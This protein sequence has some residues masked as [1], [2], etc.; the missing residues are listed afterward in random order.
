MIGS[1]GR[2]GSRDAEKKFF[3]LFLRI[4]I[5][6]RGKVTTTSVGA[7]DGAPG[8]LR[9]VVRGEYNMLRSGAEPVDHAA[10]LDDVGEQREPSA[11]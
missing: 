5:P 3:L 6:K 1:R 7:R 4:R 8:G 2:A 11:E 10:E 9:G